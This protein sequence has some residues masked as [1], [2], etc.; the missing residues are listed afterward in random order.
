[1]VAIMANDAPVKRGRPPKT[2]KTQDPID[3]ERRNAN[4]KALSGTLAMVNNTACAMVKAD[5][6]ALSTEESD[7]IANGCLAVVDELD[8]QVSPLTEAVVNLVT[9]LAFVYGSKIAMHKMMGES[10]DDAKTDKKG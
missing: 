10:A 2:A 3:I 9:S 1:M 4:Q 8:I 6:L 5:Y 7:L